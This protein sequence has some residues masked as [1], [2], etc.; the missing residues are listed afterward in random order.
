[1]EKYRSTAD[2]ST[3][4]HPFIPSADNTSLVVRLIVLLTL[5]PVRC[6]A[7]LF[8]I[9]LVLFGILL[10]ALSGIASCSLSRCCVR[11]C[12]R[13][14]LRAILFGFG[15]WVYSCPTLE[16]P[17]SRMCAVD[18]PPGHGDIVLCNHSS[19]LDPLYLACSFSPIFV[20]ATTSGELIQASLWQAVSYASS[21]SAMK[22][23]QC[24]SSVV[25]SLAECAKSA[26]EK[27]SGPIV[28][29]AEGV[30]T[31]GA[32]VLQFPNSLL[33]YGSSRVFALGLKYSVSRAEAFTV[34][35][36]PCHMLKML[37]SSRSHI[38]GRI[39]GVA[40]DSDVQRAVADL[41]GVPA[42]RVSSEARIR[43]EAHMAE[44]AR[45]Y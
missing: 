39:A 23:T 34:G 32:G 44:T 22:E 4:V 1:M 40:P 12:D 31:N 18:S 26:R 17:R 25:K 9:A 24:R 8:G 20:Y 3:G 38:T 5:L 42:L 6:G 41:A 29:F 7:I 43:F 36:G 19:Y 13:V 10:G 16:R 2:P 27:M 28:V 15:V 35:S 37:T 21:G 14:G 11:I 33:Q 45:G 30:T